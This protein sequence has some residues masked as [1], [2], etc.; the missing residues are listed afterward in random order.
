[1]SH[2]STTALQPGQE[3]DSIPSPCPQKKEKKKRKAEEDFG[4][5]TGVSPSGRYKAEQQKEFKSSK[6]AP[7]RHDT[8][9]SQKGVKM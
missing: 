8:T 7:V 1:M 4:K 6:I 3:R 9:L 2:D 5:L